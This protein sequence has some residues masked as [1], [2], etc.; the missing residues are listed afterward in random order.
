[1]SCDL[2]GAIDHPDPGFNGAGIELDDRGDLWTVS[3]NSGVAFLI[4]SGLPVF[5]D[6]PWLKVTPG[7]GSIGPDHAQKLSVRVS[8]A[9]L[10]PGV[11]RADIVLTTNDPEAGTMS[12]PVEL[13]VPAYERGINAGGSDLV[14]HSGIAYRHDRA[15]QPG[16]FGYVR[17]GEV[18]STSHAIAGTRDDPVYQ[19]MRT[20][21]SKYRFDVPRNGM[22]TVRLRFA[23]IEHSSRGDRVF[24]IFVEGQP[25]RVNLDVFRAVG[26][27]RAYDLTV[28]IRVRDRSVDVRFSGQR[29]DQPMI[30]G[31]LVTHR[32]D[33]GP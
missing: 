33:L 30:S 5:S 27:F 1:V 13:V 17:A 14:T 4:E 6:A 28:P 16:G 15:Y 29:G 8:S 32:P 7:S 25:V 31:I 11:Y 20:G 21:M 23:E 3:Q 18:R 22:Y 9:G 10:E 12:V 26:A 2:L 19:R 24:T